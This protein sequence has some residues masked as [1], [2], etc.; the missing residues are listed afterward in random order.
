MLRKWI[1]LPLLSIGLHAAIL[2][3]GISL[4]PLLTEIILPPGA[5][6]QDQIYITNTGDEPVL[7]GVKILGF[8]APEGLPI[9]LE[10]E[11]DRYPYSGRDILT[12]EPLEQKVEPGET[13]VFSYTLTMPKDLNPF[14][15]RY[16]AAIF[17]VKPM[18]T[19]ESQVIIS[20]QVASLF[21]V[22]PGP[23][24]APHL[25]IEEVRLYQSRGDPQTV[26]LEALI[27]NDGNL[28]VSSEQIIGWIYVTDADG[29]LIDKFQVSTH[30]MLPANKYIHRE[31]WKA[32]E[33]LP[34]GTYQFHLD[35][36]I[37]TPL[38]EEPQR[39]Y[40]T[41]PLELEF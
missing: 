26:I 1:I 38:G 40:L 11:L 14:G 39:Y 23:G 20:T 22:S 36:W 15:G 37:F 34:S 5:S 6:Y 30:T 16:V 25:K 2:G 8:M 9:F 27:T 28:H 19:G 3:A 35:L 24:A 29:Y 31:T 4:S 7:V 12:V 21:L 32:P 17:K 33:D 10:P 13:G 18:T 41:I